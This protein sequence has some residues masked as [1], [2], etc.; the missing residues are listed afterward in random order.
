MKEAVCN[1]FYSTIIEAEAKSSNSFAE[2]VQNISALSPIWDFDEV[3]QEFSK[4]IAEHSAQA[5]R[6]RLQTIKFDLQEQLQ[7]QLEPLFA[8]DELVSNATKLWE[9]L[10]ASIETI[11]K[12][13]NDKFGE[14]AGSLHLQT[15][16]KG[17]E[18]ALTRSIASTLCKSFSEAKIKRIVKLKYTVLPMH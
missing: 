8:E 11:F 1:E 10:S 2:S 6:S 9:H 16:C 12:S 7:N 14:S 17:F 18:L 4:A 3:S 13:L 5:L 15:E